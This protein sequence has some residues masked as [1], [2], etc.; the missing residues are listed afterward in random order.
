RQANG[1][2]AGLAEMP[3]RRF[4][5]FNALGAALWV[6]AW[7]SLGDLAGQHLNTLYPA[8]Q[9]YELYLLAAAAVLTAALLARR[10]RCRRASG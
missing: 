4:L 5:A 3:W 2:I 7:V 6:G 1:I 9:R 8:I 10:L